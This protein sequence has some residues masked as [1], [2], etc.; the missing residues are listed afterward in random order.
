MR[1]RFVSLAFSWS[2]VPLLSL[3]LAVVCAAASGPVKSN[4]K[5]AARPAV[6]RPTD[7]H[8]HARLV[9]QQIARQPITFFPVSTT[10]PSGAYES[11]LPSYDLQVR[12]SG[13]TIR[14]GRTVP[15]AAVSK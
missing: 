3:S 4:A 8:T 12:P 1:D 2:I 9:R 14:S 11:H 10:T 6:Q 13:M 7:P 15:Q 5:D